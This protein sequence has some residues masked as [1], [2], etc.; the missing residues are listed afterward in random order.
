LAKFEIKK[1]QESLTAAKKD[2]TVK[3]ASDAAKKMLAVKDAESKKR[4]EKTD[5]ENELEKKEIQQASL[6]T[7]SS[8]TKLDLFGHPVYTGV[9]NDITSKSGKRF[10]IIE[11]TF[12]AKDNSPLI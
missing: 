12:T 10:M 3:G 9:I 11:P 2:A 8:I 4:Y 6:Q 7:F 5:E 1:A